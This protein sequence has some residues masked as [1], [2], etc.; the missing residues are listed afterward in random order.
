MV[1]PNMPIPVRSLTPGDFV[2]LNSHHGKQKR[3]AVFEEIA[4]GGELAEHIR[5]AGMSI[6]SR[7]PNFLTEGAAVAVFTIHT[8]HRSVAGIFLIQEDGSVRDDIGHRIVI[9]RRLS[10][11]QYI[12]A[13][14]MASE[15]CAHRN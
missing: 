14:A 5:K 15:P 10:K 13:V 9:E 1:N 2:I 3:P 6:Q 12:A 8:A 11:E 4:N 7:G